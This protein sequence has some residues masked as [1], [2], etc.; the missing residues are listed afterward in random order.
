VASTTSPA[1]VR[2]ALIAFSVAALLVLAFAMSAS[3]ED[4]A[5]APA[6]GATGATGSV[7][8]LGADP[9]VRV[10]TRRHCISSKFVMSPQ[11]TGGGGIAASFLYLNGEAAAARRSPG[12]LTVSF[13]RLQT[14]INSYELVSI[15]TDGRSAS[16]V[17]T[18]RRCGGH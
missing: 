16:A 6:S 2:A 4:V 9:T 18:F 13:K 14:G 8:S 7:S 10:A 17:G 3:A 5:P 15:F 11:Y 12:A 1:R